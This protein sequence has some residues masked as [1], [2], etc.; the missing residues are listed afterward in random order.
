MVRKRAENGSY[1]HEPPYTEAEEEDF[2]RRTG[3]IVGVLK[4]DHRPTAHA[5]VPPP[6]PQKSPPRPPDE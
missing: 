1:Y 4:S 5:V 2:Y 6:S 3:S